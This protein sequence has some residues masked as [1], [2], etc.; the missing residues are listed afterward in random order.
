MA[1]LLL[2]ERTRHWSRLEDILAEEA[3]F[4]YLSISD[5]H[6]PWLKEQGHSA[7]TWRLL[8]GRP[9]A[10]PVPLMTLVMFAEALEI[11]RALFGGGYEE[12]KQRAHHT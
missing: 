6:F 2:P 1:D 5:H 11:I 12:C 10:H 4:D 3:S 9:R 7:Y 8:S